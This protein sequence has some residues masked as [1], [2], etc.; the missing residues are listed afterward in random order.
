VDRGRVSGAARSPHRQR[1]RP[2]RR[3]PGLAIDERDGHWHVRGTLR[4]A[5]NSRRI[6][7][8][9]E[10]PATPE[11]RDYAEALRAKIER[12]G[13][14][15][16]VHGLRPSIATAIACDRYLRRPRRRPIGHREIAAIREI[17]GKF[18][19]RKLAAISAAEWQAF[20]D[21]R[22]RGNSLASR[23]RYITAVRAF[24]NWCRERQWIAETPKF[25][26]DKEAARPPKRRARR[27]H[28]LT[29]ELIMLMI[30]H[31]APHLKAQLVVEWCT[32]AR[33]SSVL[34]GC[35]LCD[36]I[37]VAGR[38]Q[39]TF[40]DTK[41]GEPVV[42]ALNDWAVEQ[43][44]DYLEVRGGRLDDRE[45]PFFLTDEGLA[46]TDN[47]KTSGGQN[48]SAFKGMRRRTVKTIRARRR[49][50]L[51]PPARR[52]SP[53]RPC[54]DRGCKGPG[55]INRLGDAALVPAQAGNRDG[56]ADRRFARDD[57]ARR[58]EG[59]AERHR[60][61]A[62][63]PGTPAPADRRPADRRWR[64]RYPPCGATASRQE[65]DM[66]TACTFEGCPARSDRPALDGWGFLAGWPG[67]RNGPYCPAH[68]AAIEAVLA[69]GGFD[70][71][72][73]AAGDTSLTRDRSGSEKAS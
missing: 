3:P 21:D 48:K 51:G 30:E 65:L 68:V 44:L 36:L 47:G 38:G 54:G 8:S 10:L 62:R 53:R 72:E 40:H 22:Q 39:I 15:E 16:I 12:E 20:V 28:D 19:Q 7:Q 70:E 26:R 46:Y 11:N 61:H 59:R 25:E 18:A 5:G 17:D 49:R 41:N 52:R 6:R 33:V 32:G 27:V 9:T 63:R 31:A 29:P 4:A 45:Q 66:R 37:L 64:Q 58:L 35:R 1:K 23:E 13:R 71:A 50:G 69:E 57:G 14:D 2:T 56:V 34:Y 42:A 67:L 43:L 60:L 24:L 73:N 55:G